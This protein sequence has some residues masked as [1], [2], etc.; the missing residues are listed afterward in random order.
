VSVDVDRRVL[1]EAERHLRSFPERE[2]EFLHADGREPLPGGRLFDRVM[3]TAAT[4]DL[5]PAWL[6]EVHE[7]GMVLAPLALAPGLACTVRGHV[8]GGVFEGSLVRP[9][10]FMPLRE[11]E[12]VTGP[13]PTA[14]AAALPSPDKLQRVAAP[15]GDWPE[16]KPSPGAPAYPQALAFLGW[17]EGLAVAFQS[18]PD[19]RPTYGVGD[20]VHGHAC[21]LGQRDWRVTGSAG[22]DLGTRLWRTYLDA[23]GP[24]PTEFRLR[25]WPAAA[26]TPSWLDGASGAR[27]TYCRDGSR[28]RQLWELLD[29]RE[30]PGC[31]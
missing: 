9:A 8:H 31:F 17:L 14:A 16:R 27:L 3:V 20:L 28:C 18:G 24:W 7:G 6:G 26:T 10:Y 22:H 19:G 11:E 2:V 13:D 4:P 15:W 21:W 12:G 5:E 25:A 23:G 29:P 30:R 1:A